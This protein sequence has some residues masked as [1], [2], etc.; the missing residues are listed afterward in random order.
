M[1]KVL[2]IALSALMLLSLAAC[3]TTNS[4]D[5]TVKLEGVSAPLDIL[6]TVANSYSEDERIPG[7]PMELDVADK[8]SLQGLLVCPSDAADMIDGAA[9]Y[10]HMMMANNF[11]AGAYHIAEGADQAAFVSAM[12][13]AIKNN[14]WMCGF[15]EKLVIATLADDYVVV[16]FG[17]GDLI[18]NFKTK[19]SASYDVT[20]Y[21]V[22]EA[23]A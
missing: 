6:T 17:A 5:A 8:E 19:L 3:G 20:V 2:A 1:K 13:D 10:I 21:A 11:T 23:L 15:P 22:E 4:G 12:Q 14:H 18:D 9:H 16:A 7:D